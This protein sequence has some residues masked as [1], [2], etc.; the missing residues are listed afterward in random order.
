MSVQPSKRSLA[1]ARTLA[2]FGRFSVA[3]ASLVMVAGC[4]NKQAGGAQ[5]PERQSQSE[6]DIARDLFHKGDPRGALDHARMAVDLDDGNAKALYFV[7][8]LYA[9]FCDL[10]QGLEG[11][12]CKIDEAEKYA[13]MAVKTDGNLRDGKNLLGQI[14]ILRGQYAEAATVLEPLTKDPAYASSHLAW[15]NYGWALVNQGKLDEGIIAL[16]NSTI[17]PKFCVGHYRLASAYEK[18]G[19]LNRAEAELTHALTTDRPECQALQDA[20][21]A[22]GNVRQRLGRLE[23]A[24]ADFNQCAEL[25]PKSRTGKRCAAK[26]HSLA[27]T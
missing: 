27:G 1:S 14:L 17:E 5:S 9:F 7:S 20:W 18:K 2:R 12:D 15:G 26:S 22:R 4:N 8:V 25:G 11:A 3:L 10:D 23:E 24:A 21:E 6:F 19:D 13:R 16:Q